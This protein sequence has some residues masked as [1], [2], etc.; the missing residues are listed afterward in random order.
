[1]CLE[2]LKTG[3]EGQTHNVSHSFTIQDNLNFPLFTKDWTAKENLLLIQGIMKCGMGNWTDIAEQ[4]VKTKE[5]KQ[6]EEYY[7]S[8]LYKSKT[9]YLPNLEDCI[10]KSSRIFK[11][12]LFTVDIDEE[13]A[14]KALK[15]IEDYQ[16]KSKVE[17]AEEEL[18]FT[19]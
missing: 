13:K 3:G 7:Y 17:T 2:C 8:F 12:G 19:T 15:K 4:Y 6:C 11:N 14:K 5:P 16:N 1:M 10:G 9:D 18:E